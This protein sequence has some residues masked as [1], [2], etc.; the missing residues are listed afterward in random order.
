MKLPSKWEQVVG[1]AVKTQDL[2]KLSYFL[3]S[4]GSIFEWPNSLVKYVKEGTEVCLIGTAG[5]FVRLKNGKTI[6]WEE[7]KIAL[8]YHEPEFSERNR[9][10]AENSQKKYEEKC[11][12]HYGDIME[13]RTGIDKEIALA[14]WDNAFKICTK[15][16]DRILKEIEEANPDVN[17]SKNTFTEKDGVA[18]TI[19]K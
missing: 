1:R 15:E 9:E 6:K 8:K 10:Y 5:M 17:N 7:L 4:D 14:R 3:L 2:G 16:R 13:A 12:S 19:S 18:T 11:R